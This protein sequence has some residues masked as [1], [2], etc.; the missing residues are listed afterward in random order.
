MGHHRSTHKLPVRVVLRIPNN[1]GGDG[2]QRKPAIP[3]PR[4]LNLQV[5]DENK[6]QVQ[7]TKSDFPLSTSAAAKVA[8]Q[9]GLHHGKFLAN[10]KDPQ[11][12]NQLIVKPID[13]KNPNNLL[14]KSSIMI[15]TVS[16]NTSPSKSKAKIYSG[17]GESKVSK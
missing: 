4:R 10:I 7:S 5:P 16:N 2:Y 14:S 6:L 8:A 15:T 13:F 17:S 11:N 3:S 1:N 12:F 9:K